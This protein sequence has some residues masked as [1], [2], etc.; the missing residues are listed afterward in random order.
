MRNVTNP[1]IID[2]NY[3]DQDAPCQEQVK[4]PP[5]MTMTLQRETTFL[6]FFLFS[7]LF[8]LNI[9]FSA[10]EW[11][12]QRSAVQLSDVVYQN[13]RGTSA[14]EVA[15]KFDCSRNVPCR[16]IYVQD[17]ILEPEGNGG[18]TA[19]CDNVRYVNRGNLFP[20]CSP[21]FT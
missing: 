19:S 3:C 14:S 18:T 7:P 17:V 5:S 6:S 2:Q 4:I 21:K 15:I 9:F 16:D 13:I 1:I 12:W 20:Q 11:K 8:F 10:L